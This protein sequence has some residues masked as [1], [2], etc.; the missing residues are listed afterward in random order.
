MPSPS[1]V[2]EETAPRE[3]R[4]AA[5]WYTHGWNNR[6][7]WELIL[8]IIPWVPWFL[9]IPLHHLTTLLCFA[10]MTRERAAVRRNLARVTGIHGWANLRLAYRVFFNFSRFMVAYTE[11]KDLDP[12]RFADR[13]DGKDEAEASV[14]MVLEEGRGAII[15]TMHIGHWDLGLKLLSH[16]KVPVH[17]VMLSEDAAEVTRYADE[18]RSVS[19]VEVHQMGRSPLLGV[20]LMTRLLRGEL[21]AIQA[22][23]PVGH[24]VMMTQFFGAPASL[25]TGPVQLAM[26]TGAP[27]LPVFVLFGKG[28]RYRL[29]TLAPMRFERPRAEETDRSL[30]EAMGRMTG[31]MESVI[32]R[33]PDQWFNFYDIWPASQATAQSAGGEGRWRTRG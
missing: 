5:R 29:H 15:V 7:S 14:K 26:A 16:F 22:D 28:R 9:L 8:R 10:C 13:V 23:R 17:V 30:R 24:S 32:T 31:M 18:A 3:G 25:P 20:E 6:L 19:N 21:V 4:P 12:A 27:L 2:T 11:M 1:G 33:Y